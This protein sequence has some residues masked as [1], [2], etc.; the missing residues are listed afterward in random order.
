M[1]QLR[2]ALGMRGRT[3]GDKVVWEGNL[4]MFPYLPAA[5]M[6][7]RSLSLCPGFV[8]GH[9][10]AESVP[11]LS[12]DWVS[13]LAMCCAEQPQGHSPMLSLQPCRVGMELG[14]A[15]RAEPGW[16]QRAELEVGH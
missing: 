16:A 7:H 5:R 11:H 14:W 4:R 8:T 13:G 12:Q 9:C 3:A 1:S 15:Q 10:E 6:S 2:L